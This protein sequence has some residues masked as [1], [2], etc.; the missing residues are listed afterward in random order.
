MKKT[1]QDLKTETETI[2]KTQAK[3]I[4]ETEMMRKQPG[5]INESINSKIQEMEGRISNAEVQLRKQTHQSKK[6]LNL[7]K[8]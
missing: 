5:T 6:A 2:K 8:A 7:T 4:I 3:E 1:I